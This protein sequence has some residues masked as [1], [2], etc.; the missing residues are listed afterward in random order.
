MTAQLDEQRV[1]TE[2]CAVRYSAAGFT[3]VGLQT[4][5]LHLK[6]DELKQEATKRAINST[7][8]CMTCNNI[9]ATVVIFKLL[10]CL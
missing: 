1:I 5:G 7:P 2:S 8:V 6:R 9:T 4:L 10:N 3:V